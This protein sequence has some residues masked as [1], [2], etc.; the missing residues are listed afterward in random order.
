MLKI[1][2]NLLNAEDYILIIIP[3]Q[4]S[5]KQYIQQLNV[6]A[7]EKQI[8]PLR[9]TFLSSDLF[10]SFYPYYNDNNS[11]SAATKSKA[12]ATA[13]NSRL[14]KTDSVI[15]A[16]S[17]C[18][19]SHASPLLFPKILPLQLLQ[20]RLSQD[21]FPNTAVTHISPSLICANTSPFILCISCRQM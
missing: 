21:V 7:S 14:S 13:P 4:L 19:A 17:L 1:L 16:T 15:I 2:S 11:K 5:H 3:Q 9:Q 20:T 10:C 6:T 18:S 12:L 8:F